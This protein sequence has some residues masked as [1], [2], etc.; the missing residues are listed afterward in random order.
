VPQPAPAPP[1]LTKPK[2]LKCKPGFKK[3]KVRGKLK[4]V[5]KKGKGKH[6]K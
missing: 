5:K 2:P 6:R 3:T 1:V 4:C